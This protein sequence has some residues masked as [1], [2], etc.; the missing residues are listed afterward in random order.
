MGLA[1]VPDPSELVLQKAF[2]LFQVPDPPRALGFHQALVDC[3]C[4]EVTES[5]ARQTANERVKFL[6]TVRRRGFA[7]F[8][9]GLRQDII[10]IAS[11]KG[12]FGLSDVRKS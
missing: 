8:M 2:A 6:E 1:N 3:A 5:R 7:V 10:L 11:G 12:L 4:A 9:G